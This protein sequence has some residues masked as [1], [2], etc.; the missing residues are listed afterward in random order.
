MCLVFRKQAEGIQLTEVLSLLEREKILSQKM[1]CENV[2][3]GFIKCPKQ[4]NLE[5]QE[6]GK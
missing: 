3:H 2:A 4:S 5:G 6:K 1:Q